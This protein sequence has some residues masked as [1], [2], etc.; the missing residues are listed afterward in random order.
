MF[1]YKRITL[2]QCQPG[3]QTGPS[4]ISFHLHEMSR[5]GR[6]RDGKQT[7]EVGGTGGN[8]NDC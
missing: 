8:G 2:L 6:S 1:V 3:S 4:I 7:G 5:I